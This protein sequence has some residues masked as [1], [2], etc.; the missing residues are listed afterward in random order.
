VSDEIDRAYEKGYRRFVCGGALGF[1]TICAEAVIEKR[2]VH[3]D[4]MLVLVIPCLGQEDGWSGED[5]DTYDR[6]YAE[7][8]EC[9][10]MSEQYT[11]GCMHLRNRAMVDDSSLCIAYLECA[12][13]GTAYTYKYAKKNGLVVINIADD[14]IDLDVSGDDALQGEEE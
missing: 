12:T 7:C 1:D 5:R 13:G 4:A 11:E 8:D 2:K 6:I 9:Y 3:G 14:P 10:C